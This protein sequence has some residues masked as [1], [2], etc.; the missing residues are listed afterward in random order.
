MSVTNEQFADVEGEWGLA[1]QRHGRGWFVTVG[2]ILVLLGT[3]ALASQVTASL[4]TAA[5]IGVLL[6]FAGIVEII[7]AYWNRRWRGFLLQLLSGAVLATIG[8][9][10]VREP[11]D[12]GLA[13]AMLLACILMVG[14][15][16]RVSGAG[17]Y[18]FEGWA[19]SLVSGSIDLLLGMMIWLVWPGGGLWMLGLFVGIS[20]IFRGFNWIGLG[21]RVR[22]NAW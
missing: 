21:V 16:L 14:G 1:T 2:S 20:L 13:L 8:A 9:M 6:L 19:W 5:V 15:I 11:V 17:T 3:I 4:V 18:Q 7:C 10:F 22:G 12:A